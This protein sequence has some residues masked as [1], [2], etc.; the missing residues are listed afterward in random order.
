[1]HAALISLVLMSGACGK[2]PHGEMSMPAPMVSVAVPAVGVEGPI[3]PLGCVSCR[4]GTVPVLYRG[5]PNCCPPEAHTK[6][7]WQTNYK[8]AWYYCDRMLFHP[9][10]YTQPYPYRERFNYPWNDPRVP[11]AVPPIGY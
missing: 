9:A 6:P 1:M 7:A 2:V 3:A 11:C 10:D 8:P 5:C 4:N